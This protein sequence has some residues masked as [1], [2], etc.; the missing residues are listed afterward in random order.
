MEF[1]SPE[2]NHVLK[3]GDIVSQI[4]EEKKKCLF[5]STQCCYYGIAL[6]ERC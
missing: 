3:E 1:K 2:I 6:G 5:R 4:S